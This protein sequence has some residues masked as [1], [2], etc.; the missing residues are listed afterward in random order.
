M[1][2]VKLC[3]YFTRIDNYDQYYIKLCDKD[4]DTQNT[5]HKLFQLKKFGGDNPI[6]DDV[7]VLKEKKNKPP[8][9][10]N[11]EKK[12]VDAKELI[13]SIVEVTCSFRRYNFSDKYGWVLDVL[14]ISVP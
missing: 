13:G 11:K 7:V 6:Y 12:I 1:P 10:F 9:F 8:F 4:Y 14:E 5:R 3:G 2:I